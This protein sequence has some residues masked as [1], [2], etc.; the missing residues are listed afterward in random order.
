MKADAAKHLVDG[1]Y[2][3]KDLVDLEELRALFQ[4][5]TDAM[6]FTIGFLNVPDNEV[7]IATG[8]RDLCTK[9]HRQCPRAA[10]RCRASNARLIR[11]LKRPGQ[12]VIEACGNGLVD[13]ATPIIIHGKKIAILATGQVLLKTPKIEYFKKQAKLFGCGEAAYLRALK[14]VPVISEKKLK[15]ATRFL[16]ELAHMIIRMGYAGLA[17]KQ[18]RE[19]LTREVHQR[20]RMESDLR[21]IISQREALFGAL[22]DGVVVAESET[23]RI[24]QVNS[25]AC[26][27]LGYTPK[28]LLKK[29][30]FALHPEEAH[31]KIAGYLQELMRR[32]K[33]LIPDVLC[34][35][36]GG[37][38]FS[39][40][41][42]ATPAIFHG[43]KCLVGFF[44]DVTERKRSEERE[45]EAS[46]RLQA[47]F[48][49]TFQFIAL[50]SPNGKVLEAN[51]SALM[52][53]GL[54]PEAV[55]GRFFWNCRW[56]TISRSTQAD[57]RKAVAQAARGKFIRYPV[58]V[59]GGK[60][61][62]VA[63]DF[64]LKPVKNDQGKVMLLTAEGRDITESKRSEEALKRSELEKLMVLE[65]IPDLVVYQ[66]TKNKVVWANS[67]TAKAFGKKLEEI[68]GAT[69]YKVFHGR[70]RACVGCP[71]N[72]AKKTGFLEQSEMTSPD[73]R[74]WMISGSP[75]KDASGAVIGIV[76]VAVDITEKRR[77]EE[78]LRESEEKY[79]LMFKTSSVGMA[80]CE[81]DGSLI[82]VNQAY[83][84]IIGYTRKEALGLSYWDL[85]PKEYAKDEARQLRSME[86]TGKYGP[87]TKEYIKKTGERVDV[88]LTGAVVL[89]ADGVRR[90][91]SLVESITERKKAEASLAA[92]EKRFRDIFESSQDAMMTIEAPSW[93]FASANVS[94]VRMFKA[95]N[96]ESLLSH[97]PWELSPKRQPDGRDSRKKARQ[98]IQKAIRKGA[99]FFEWTHRRLDGE[100]FAA[101]VLLNRVSRAEGVCLQAT[102]R[103]ITER[104][105]S[106]HDLLAS[107]TRYRRFFECA[108]DGIL[109]LNAATGMIE[110]V[111][112]FLIQMLGYSHRAFLGKKLWEVGAFKDTEKCRKAFRVLQKRK[113]IRYDDM[114]LE[115][116]E[117]RLIQAEFIS[118]VYPVDGTRVIQCNIRDI[119][120]RNQMELEL[121][122][123]KEKLEYILGMTRTGVDVIDPHF[124]LRY[125]D[126]AWQKV[127]GNP[128]GRKCYEY[129]MG[130]NT[131]C[132]GCGIPRALRTRKPT[133]TEEILPRE[134]N[135]KIEVH[136]I[137]YRDS[138]GEWLVAEF[139]IDITERKKAEDALRE[140][141]TALDLALNAARMGVWRFDVVNQ[142]RYF[143]DQVFRLLGIDPATFSGKPEE[144]FRAIH[145]D[146]R[147]KVHSAFARALTKNVP[148]DPEYRVVWP[149]KSVHYIAA[150]GKLVND[151]A[152]RPLQ[153]N[154][155]LW[156]VTDQKKA[157]EVL[158]ESRL[159]LRRIIDTVPH[160]I[161]AKDQSGRFL[162]V[163]RA[164]AEAYQ[165]EPRDL[166][167]V[168]RQDIHK[169]RQEV[170]GFLKGDK[171]VLASGRSALVSNESF[172]DAR[173][174]KHDLQTIKIPF[175]MT[176]IKD[177]CI[178]GVSVDV[179]EQK[180][181]EEF[182]NDIVRTVSHELRTPLSIEKEGISLL[183]D[184][185]LGPVTAE[186]MEILKTV[187]RSIDRLARM[188]T[189]LLDISSIETGKIHL[190]Q[191]VT[192]LV[193]LVKDA[194]FEF[195]K[196]A[197][198][199]SVDLSVKLP[200]RPVQVH[201]DPDKI[202]QVLS[203]LVDNAVKFTERGSVE[204][205]LALLQNTVECEVRDTGIGIAPEN[206]S[207]LFEKFQQFS[208][209]IGPGEKGFGL[210]L[211]IVKG[212]IE[213]HG[214]QIWVQSELGK[215]TCVTFSLPLYQ[216]KEV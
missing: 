92:S 107:E 172:T 78:K 180:R 127:Y 188:I 29:R 191:K 40:D 138:K 124:N 211:S 130:R 129:F 73:G 38:V 109:I 47:V 168:R 103:D 60:G 205:S 56:W 159:Q 210:G 173:G 193:G 21:E 31:K 86:M 125:V 33:T 17:E 150:R 22:K 101:E 187:M 39:A 58:E 155:V 98:M 128:H 96:V 91:W 152:G 79:R 113:Y 190:S 65:N 32:K 20:K 89:G 44:R 64:S 146:D 131:M 178:L 114:P 194:A 140:S 95:K 55:R 74:R 215:G 104:R 63:I 112:P 27:L 162:L 57:L 135:R 212:I 26:H 134:G 143:D 214:G 72:K 9:F 183:M 123:T 30:I 71:I 68:A 3:I 119:T 19:L 76:E 35:K 179:T 80:L 5:F 116:K 51:R 24:L 139:N 85:T 88:M 202:M 133:I 156:D 163:N 111:N 166:I 62:K 195:K 209:T 170:E 171:E 213:M 36:K 201:A 8:W 161:F 136:T 196:R 204:I 42:A 102:V 164:V 176:G 177:L 185:M 117:G 137:P 154:G 7:L 52:F 83:L 34:R 87:Y 37:T 206:V 181:V 18:Y 16:G 81:M 186:Q 167:G 120:V 165:R 94:M 153:L 69:C 105:R 70:D 115:T 157:E 189:S 61:E 147:S 54:T 11:H 15:Q 1:K 41:I 14:E 121:K 199:K 2:S 97:S 207:K 197:E 93:R 192:D 77:A 75:V 13:C 126:P 142:K 110:D 100:V 59:L 208:R 203:N 90:I 175:K 50:L 48:D 45:R 184:E 141:K 160:M 28:Q 174:Y 182:R 82:E 25:Q 6:G 148:Y 99:N 216:K 151:P 67:S 106:E 144:F 43:K 23:G 46:Q 84:D 53:G 169:N 66:D 108:K 145:P 118:N 12:I 158:R 4:S 149:D 10:S 132:P 198:A 49:S 200:R 122:D